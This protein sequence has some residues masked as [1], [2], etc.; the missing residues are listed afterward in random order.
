M[1]THTLYSIGIHYGPS[2]IV[3]PANQS[4]ATNLVVGKRVPPHV[5]IR[6]SDADVVELQDLI[7]SNTRFKLLFFLGDVK[8]QEQRD[9]IDTMACR[10][11]YLRDHP[12]EGLWDLV[13]LCEGNKYERSPV[14][15]L[16]ALLRPHWSK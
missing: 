12:Y 9:R 11:T 5:F 14:T 16:P 4:Y 8:I 13:T 2:P 6:S 15:D 7:V 10:L 3:N 1:L